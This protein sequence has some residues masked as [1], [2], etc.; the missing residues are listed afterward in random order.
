MGSSAFRDWPRMMRRATASA[1]CDLSAAEFEREVSA[2]RLPQPVRLGN[3]EHWSRIAID[4]MLSRLSG[5][6]LPSWREKSPLYNS[7]A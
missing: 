7:A 4:E 3:S 5:E 6:S 2:G 1:Y